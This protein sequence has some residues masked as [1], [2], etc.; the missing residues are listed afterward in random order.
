MGAGKGWGEA[1]WGAGNPLE[2]LGG[3]GCLPQREVGLRRSWFEPTV[4]HLALDAAWSRI[5]AN[6]SAAQ[7][8]V[9][10]SSCS[11]QALAECELCI[12]EIKVIRT[13]SF[14]VLCLQHMK[15]ET[16]CRI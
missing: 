5:E 15:P 14:T 13:F 9:K 4:M 8:E 10:S 3:L 11:R 2:A 12:R 7:R 1:G 16:S 6:E